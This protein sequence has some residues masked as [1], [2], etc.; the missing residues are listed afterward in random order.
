M[1][2]IFLENFFRAGIYRNSYPFSSMANS[3]YLSIKVHLML[4]QHVYRDHRS[5]YHS[6][7]LRVVICS[8]PPIKTTAFTPIS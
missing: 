4:R 5:N 2:S 1:W 7:K 6:A 8:P 3:L